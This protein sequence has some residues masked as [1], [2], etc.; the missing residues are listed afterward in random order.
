[1]AV[2]AAK[3]FDIEKEYRRAEALHAAGKNERA[4]A[5]YAR[6]LKVRPLNP[7]ALDLFGVLANRNRMF[8]TAVELLREAVACEPENIDMN[9]HL[10]LALSNQGQFD[11]ARAVYQKVMHAVPPTADHLHNYA[12]LLLAQGELVAAEEHYRRAMELDATWL[13]TWNKL[14]EVLIRRGRHVEAIPL[15]EHCLQVEPNHIPALSLLAIALAATDEEQRLA[16]LVDLER[17][18]MPMAA[19]PV[20]A[21][22]NLAEFNRQLANY[23]VRHPGLKTDLRDISTRQGGQTMGNLFDDRHPLIHAL[24]EMIGEVLATYVDRLPE[25]PDHPHCGQVPADWRLEGWGVVLR[26]GGHQAAHVH[27]DG[28]VSCVYYL[29]LPEIIQADDPQQAGWIQFGH[30]PNDYY[31]DV[32]PPTRRIQ[33]QEGYFVMFPS[34]FWHETIPFTSDEARICIA[35]DVI[36]RDRR[37]PR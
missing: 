11:A 26:S 28:W 34:Y 21:F 30:G 33:P 22:P 13:P 25:L 19:R 7:P 29:S 2:R 32:V 5:I 36:P 9:F 6:L 16:T 15:L 10:A 8:D 3:H 31:G 37:R 23:V 17:F 20:A 4:R 14:A 24:R 18:I 35:F 27:F 12:D 1:M